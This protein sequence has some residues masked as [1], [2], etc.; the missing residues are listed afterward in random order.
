MNVAYEVHQRRLAVDLHAPT[1]LLEVGACQGNLPFEALSVLF[2][3][4]LRESA[5]GYIRYLDCETG[6]GQQPAIP[7]HGDAALGRRLGDD[8]SEVITVFIRMEQ[9][10]AAGSTQDYVIDLAGFVHAW[11]KTASAGPN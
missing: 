2:G 8:G 10:L 7:I 9:R 11:K 5:D 4:P 1:L 3:N 6:L